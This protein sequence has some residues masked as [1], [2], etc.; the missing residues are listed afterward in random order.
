MGFFRFED[1]SLVLL[2][3]FFHHVESAWPREKWL[4]RDAGLRAARSKKLNPNDIIS[5]SG[6]RQS[7]G[8]VILKLFELMNQWISS[9]LPPL[10]QV[11]SSLPPPSSFLSLSLFL[12][13]SHSLFPLA[14]WV[15]FFHLQMGEFSVIHNS[16]KFVAL[17]FSRLCAPNPISSS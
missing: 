3:A 13:L 5:D 2:A 15:C 10:L 1:V 6:S 7:W 11:I 12:C 16:R 14:S 8:E 9:P 17:P 4:Q